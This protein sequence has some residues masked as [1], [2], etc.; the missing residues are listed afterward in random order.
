M[1]NHF[2]RFVSRYSIFTRRFLFCIVLCIV[3][4]MV[5]YMAHN[6]RHFVC[7]LCVW[8]GFFSLRFHAF[9]HLAFLHNRACSSNFVQ[10]IY[11]RSIHT[12]TF[13]F[14]SSISI[15]CF[16]R[17]SVYIL[18]RSFAIAYTRFYRPIC[19]SVVSSSLST[20]C[21]RYCCC[22]HSPKSSHTLLCHCP[23]P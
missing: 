5:C 16:N 17:F 21:N 11:I 14:P 15:L 23:C 8:S 13:Q 10:Y 19:I 22:R 3:C 9:L 20:P 1:L 18:I 7:L 6:G 2:V 12:G 4:I